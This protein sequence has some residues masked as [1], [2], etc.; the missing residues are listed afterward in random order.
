MGKVARSRC[1]VPVHQRDSAAEALYRRLEWQ[2]IR[3]GRYEDIDVTVM[4]TGL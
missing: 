4:R 2:T 3:I 1:P